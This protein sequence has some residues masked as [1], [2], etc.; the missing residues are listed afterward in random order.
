MTEE[1]MNIGEHSEDLQN[2]S[3]FAVYEEPR[4]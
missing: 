2:G 3:M 4:H 1:M